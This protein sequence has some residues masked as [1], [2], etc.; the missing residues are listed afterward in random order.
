MNTSRLSPLPVTALLIFAILLP[1]GSSVSLQNFEIHM[2]GEKPMVDDEKRYCLIA[3]IWHEADV[4]LDSPASSVDIEMWTGDGERN[5]SDYYHWEYSNGVWRDV[6]YGIY[7][8]EDKCEKT[9][10]LYSFYIGVDAD[11]EYGIWNLSVSADGETI[12]T[13][14]ISVKEARVGYAIYPHLADSPIWV[15]PFEPVNLTLTDDA[16]AIIIENN[17]NYPFS[18]SL[19]FSALQDDIKLIEKNDTVHVGERI[20]RHISINLPAFSPRI[21]D[22]KISVHMSPLYRISTSSTAAL[23]TEQNYN[24]TMRIYIGH[25]GYHIIQEKGFT[26]QKKDSLNVDYN[27]VVNLTAFVSGNG[28]MLMYL[29]GINC[30]IIELFLDG[31]KVSHQP[32]TLDLNEDKE[33]NLTVM[34]KADVPDVAAKL[35]YTI[36]HGKSNAS[37]STVLNVGPAPPPKPVS[38]PT[39]DK[40]LVAAFI[41][42]A[43]GI[44]TVYVLISQKKAAEL[45][46]KEGK[47]R[48]KARKEGRRRR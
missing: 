42:G 13:T 27:G 20:E 19:N 18:V 37:Y 33:Y 7:M 14:Q 25:S 5:A 21:I 32:I 9:G 44:V 38:P 11:V 1:Y 15:R 31:E 48:N 26:I 45:A 24:T 12:Y 39:P 4:Y 2:A 28:S 35:V 17:G 34:V 36:Y 47:G 29:D 30:T 46:R 23:L 22:I 6:E 3:G 10:T 16:H 8:D 40:T 41:I 43:A